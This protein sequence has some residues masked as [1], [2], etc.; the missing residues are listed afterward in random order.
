MSRL[1]LLALPFVLMLAVAGSAL[2]ESPLGFRTDGTGR[3]PDA[4]PPRQW[5]PEKNVVWKVELTQSNAIPVILGDKIFTCAEPCVLLCIDK[6]D[7]KILWQGES[8]YDEIALTDEEQKQREIERPQAEAI[9]L[10]LKTLGREVS[11]LRKTL[12]DAATDKET[13]EARIET[14][15]EQIKAIKADKEKLT[16]WNRY[17]EPGKGTGG[18]HPTGGYASA[19]P[20]TD[21]ER[22]YVIF[23][24]GLAACYD[25]AGNRQW[26]RLIEHPTAAYGH[27]SSPLLAGD[28][29]LVHF[30]DLVA[31]NTRDGSEAWR[32][33]V[34][35][36]HGTSMLAEAGGV[37]VAIHPSGNVY[38]ISDGEV[39][40]SK[41]GSTG[42]N[43][44]LVQDGKAFFVAGQAS[45]YQLPASNESASDWK[46]L[47]KG[48][49]LKGGGYWFPSPILH[50][51]LIYA[52]NASS[53]FSIVDA[54]TGELISEKRLDFGGGQS[55]PSLTLAG[56]LL[57]ASSDNGVTIV[58]EPGRKPKEIAQNSLETFRSSLVFEGQRMYV[59][60]TKGLWCFSEK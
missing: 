35:P 10:K 9:D 36:G 14:L 45:A 15:Q 25:L 21:G 59:R 16:T 40:A 53:I 7:G 31:L 52:M 29:L 23:G 17:L 2:G 38:R 33:K 49:R 12:Q 30:E 41:L 57:F 32:A 39:L 34:S 19:T 27:G 4:E 47:W 11:D 28:K 22:V 1:L 13:T 5:G 54:E 8:R 18:F 37:E 24:N 43:S 60:T 26:L 44:P 3:Y 42:P 56:G 51:G 46:L 48:T 6:A 58:L 55:Y 50:E 20:V